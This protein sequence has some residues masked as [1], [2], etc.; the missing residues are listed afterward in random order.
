MSKWDDVL[1]KM[2]Q[3]GENVF[4]LFGGSGLA[5]IVVE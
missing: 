1:N 4:D 5:Q 2:V 3:A